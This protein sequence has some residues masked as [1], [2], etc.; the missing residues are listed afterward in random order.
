MAALAMLRQIQARNESRQQQLLQL[1][2]V[3][4]QRRERAAQQGIDLL[5]GGAPKNKVLTVV[6]TEIDEKGRALLDIVDQNIKQQRKAQ[7]AGQ[8]AQGVEQLVGLGG[9]AQQRAPDVNA[10]INQ[11]V[12]QLQA[13]LGESNPDLLTSLLSRLGTVQTIGDVQTRAAEAKS[14]QKFREAVRLAREQAAIDQRKSLNVAEG[15]AQIGA[16]YEIQKQTDAELG[17]ALAE[18]EIDEAALDEQYRGD[19]MGAWR[20]QRAVVESLRHKAAISPFE[21]T[22]ALLRQNGVPVEKV[23]RTLLMRLTPG[24]DSNGN[25]IPPTAFLSPTTGLPLPGQEGGAQH[26][27]VEVLETALHQVDTLEAAARIA[28]E[29]RNNP[30]LLKALAEQVKAS[31]NAGLTDGDVATYYA[32]RNVVTPGIARATGEVGNLTDREQTNAQSVLPSIVGILTNPKTSRA[33]FQAARQFLLNRLSSQFNAV[34]RT[35][36]SLYRDRFREASDASIREAM[37]QYR[38]EFGGAAALVVE[39]VP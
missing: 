4:E 31:L 6:G 26:K 24:Q 3:M 10:A 37:E 38:T 21:E 32:L 13:Q 36:P 30:Q 7:E 27:T 12:A 9:P 22:V 35:Q 14:E 20:K 28:Q 2:Q 34:Y 5:M 16:R 17:R 23:P 33:Q 8:T 18:G 11:G 19:P 39:E 15:K 1:S 25:Y 29:N